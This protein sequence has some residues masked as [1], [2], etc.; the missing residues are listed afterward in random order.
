MYI[1]PRYIL[2]G[3]VYLKVYV[4]EIKFILERVTGNSSQKVESLFENCNKSKR[5]IPNFDIFM[6]FPVLQRS[7]LVEGLDCDKNPV[8]KFSY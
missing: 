8:H 6:S 2:Q 3:G 4:R 5:K 7:Y 1:G